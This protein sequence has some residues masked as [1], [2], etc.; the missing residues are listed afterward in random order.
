MQAPIDLDKITEEE[1][2][3]LK[4]CD[5][6][7]SIQGTWLE[8]CVQ[9]LYDELKSKE[10][11]FRP[12]CYLADEWLTPEWE[13]CI[14]IPFYLAH[15]ML[16]RLERK[17]MI[18]A[19]GETKSWCMKLLRHEAGHAIFYAY[20]F[21]KM[22]KWADM[23]GAPSAEYK[24]HYKFRPYSKSF[25]HHLEGYYAQ[26]HPEEDFVETFA[27]WLTPDMNWSERYKGWGAYKKLSYVD[28]LM[29]EIKG[30][31]PLVTSQRKFWRLSTLR[32]TLKKYYKKKRHFW[33]EEFPD[34]HDSFLRKVFQAVETAPAKKSSAST[35]I[36]HNRRDILNTVTKY[37]GERKYIVE[38][39]LRNLQKR[40]RELK[41][42]IT[43]NP[44]KDLIHVSSYITSLCMN[45]R[46]TGRY[47]GE[48]KKRL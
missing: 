23:F 12:A 45:Y 33:A 6:P 20:N 48:K 29:S 44:N 17:F 25:V 7:I 38:Y 16:I 15:P 40:G 4:I 3:N 36:K 35:F 22:E 32:L 21:H 10:I 24:D 46:Y 8:E 13:T 47:R 14:G 27:V 30:K 42:A 37:T 39:I 2:L 41:L 5:L 11:I 18:D 1:L 43:D 28:Q 19:E 9:Q 31:P 26:Y 34:F